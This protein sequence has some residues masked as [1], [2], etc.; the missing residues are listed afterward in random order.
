[1]AVGAA[2]IALVGWNW[3][4]LPTFVTE[5]MPFVDLAP[6]WTVAAFIATRERAVE[7]LPEVGDGR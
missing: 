7:R 5:L 6:T 1:M 2:M 3:V 4:F